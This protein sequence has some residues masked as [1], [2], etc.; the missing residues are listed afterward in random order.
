MPQETT[1]SRVQKVLRGE[2]PSDR[3]P[4]LEWAVW[5][6]LTIDRW[7]GEGLPD[8]LSNDGI[9][10]YFGLDVDYQLWFPT[11]APGATRDSAKKHWV[12]NEADYDELLSHLRPDIPP[13]DQEIW[14][15]RAAEQ[16]AGEVVI[17]ITL[18][19]FFWWP[20]VLMGI[21]PHLFAFYDKPNLMHRMNQDLVE[22]QLYSI[23]YFCQNTCVPDFMSFAEDMS[24]NHGPMISKELF[25]EFMA[26]YY[27]QIIPKL[28]QYGIVPIIDS[29]GDVEPLISWFE[30]I[31]LDGIAPLERMAGV[32]VNRIRT[33]HSDWIMVGG[34]DKTV[35]HR[36]EEAMRAE[37]ER[38]MPA[39]Q[40]GRYIPSVDHQTPPSV[41]IDD[42]R[43]YIKLLKEYATRAVEIHDFN[44]SDGSDK[45]DM[46]DKNYL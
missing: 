20:R 30:E 24:Y 26:P 3:L 19:G 11:F 38:L 1:R 7:K 21:E 46:S 28:K 34:F 12:E 13:Y 23:D 29:D 5:W 31:G 9:K 44:M 6:N 14:K 27:K 15:Q 39:I 41:S 17:W 45:S 43:I 36:G 25:D 16:A 35:M 22:Y 40:S 10:R 4:M 33:N 32:D 2:K 42:Y 37:F 8:G 18:N